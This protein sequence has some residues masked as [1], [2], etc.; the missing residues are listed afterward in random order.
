MVA[1]C[2]TE[3]ARETQNWSNFVVNIIN[4]NRMNFVIYGH[5]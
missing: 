4:K 2:Y 1:E 5:S 3:V